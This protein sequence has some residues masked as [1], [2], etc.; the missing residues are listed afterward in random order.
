MLGRIVD[1]ESDR[2]FLVKTV[3]FV[4]SEV[5]TDIECET[6]NCRHQRLT[7]GKQIARPAVAVRFL[8]A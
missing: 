5:V 4:V 1:G 3:D 7:N 8:A 6:V 2:H